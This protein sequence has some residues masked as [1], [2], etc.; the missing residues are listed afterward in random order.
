MNKRFFLLV[1]ISLLLLFCNSNAQVIIKELPLNNSNLTDSLF[2]DITQTRQIIDLNGKWNVYIPGE[3]DKKKVIMVPSNF[4]GTNELIFEKELKLTNAQMQR[5][6]QL[7]LLGINYSAEVSLNNFVIYK[8]PGGDFPFKIELPRDIFKSN[9][10]NI[11]S[12]KVHHKLLSDATIPLKQTFMLPQNLGGV[13]RDVYILSAP[14]VSVASSDFSY[15]FQ[16]GQTVKLNISSKIVNHS[17]RKDSVSNEFVFR[18][19]LISP[20]G[21]VINLSE[22]NSFNLPNRKEKLLTQSYNLS[23]VRLWS[24]QSPVS[25]T[26]SVQLFRNNELIDESIKP[27]SFYSLK[28]SKNILLLNGNTFT[29]NGTTYYPS[30]EDYSNLVSLNRLRD[31]LRII[32][33]LGFNAIRFGKVS[34]HPYCLKLCQEMGL[35]ALIELPINS[36]PAEISTKNNFRARV[37][38]FLGQFINAYR[39]FSVAAVG[40]GSSYLPNSPDHQ[41]FIRDLAGSLKENWNKLIY[42]SFAG[43]D[44]VQM[45]NIDLYG[46]EIFNHSFD[47]YQSRL[48]ALQNKLGKGRVFLSEATYSSYEG[49]TNGYLNSFSYEAQ[50]KFFSDLLE[51]SIN[52]S[53]AGY[54]LNSVFD[55]RGSSSSLTTGFNPDNVYKIGILGEDRG[56]NRIS[57]KV[58][59]SILHNTEKVTIPIGNRKD[60]APMVFILQGM[61]LALFMGFLVNSKRKFREDATRALLRPYNF[62]ADIRDQRILSGFH[63]NFLM[64]IL[65]GTSALLLIN[66]LFYFRNNI[67]FEKILLAFGAPDIINTFSYLAWNPTD[68]LIWLTAASIAFFLVVSVLIKFA[69]FFVKNKVFFSSIYYSVIWAFLPLILLLP[70]GLILYKVLAADFMTIYLLI[71]LAVFTIWIFYRLMKGIYVIFDVNPG[72]VYFYSLVFI[73]LI[74]GGILVYFQLT[75]STYY[76]ITNAYSQ[77]KLM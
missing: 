10:R 73:L 37:N 57:E 28:P 19:R 48:N 25:Y 44:I 47:S 45:E 32:K 55:Y 74:I 43:F 33:N 46:I 49:S 70:L 31:D 52:D 65:S 9:G 15:D 7:N 5:N 29:L 16:N 36:L 38:S 1:S 24:P 58:V 34:P 72:S 42:V 53:T 62:Y 59:Y 4:K 3:E 71:A 8:H 23:S 60:D 50:A 40:L 21:E 35:L 64:I 67:L 69:S 61:G 12:I 56:T 2:F 77:Y 6:L 22:G 20:S 26:L 63:S 68:G 66:L 14:V 75:D 30:Y 39:S 13:I 27:I 17:S 51:Y 76:Y 54:F 41:V 18:A 11:L